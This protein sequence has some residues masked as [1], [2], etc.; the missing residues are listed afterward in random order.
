MRGERAQAAVETAVALPLLVLVCVAG[1]Q[2]LA[3]AFAA[4]EATWAASAGARAAA[5]GENAAGAAREALP[6]VLEG[7]ATIQVDGARVRVTLRVPAL[8]P[9]LPG[10][11]VSDEAR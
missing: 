2:A 8:V 1:L 9:G 10:V 5:R 4:C 6:R 7:G 11:R 3:W